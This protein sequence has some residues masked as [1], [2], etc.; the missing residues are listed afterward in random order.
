MT[1]TANRIHDKL[2]IVDDSETMRQVIRSMLEPEGYTLSEAADGV[3][4]LDALRA[5]TEPLVVLLDYRMPNMDGWELLKHVEAD[6]EALATHEFI[7]ITADISTF[8]SAYID[9]LRRIS[10]RILAKPFT[11]EVLSG[12]VAQAIERLN[13]P[14]ERPVPLDTDA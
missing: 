9:M 2:L 11:K 13:T 4:G 7:V 3:E 10:I 5:T 6:G 14:P 1:Q 12:A 8:P